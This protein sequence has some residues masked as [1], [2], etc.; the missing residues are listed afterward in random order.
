MTIFLTLTRVIKKSKYHLK[1]PGN[2]QLISNCSN[3]DDNEELMNR[4]S[5]IYVPEALTSS[6][7]VIRKYIYLK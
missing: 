7:P 4:T 1:L 2:D 6:N 5:E 3:S